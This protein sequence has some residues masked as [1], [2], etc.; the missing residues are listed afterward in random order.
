MAYRFD[1][2]ELDPDAAVLRRDGEPVEVQPKVLDLLVLAVENAGRLL[3]KEELMQ[4]LWPGVF[5]GEESLTQV[6]RKARLALGDD[7]Q[8]PRF[9]QT[10]PRRGYRFIAAAQTIESS[11][12]SPASALAA[13]APTLPIG[14][15]A[16]VPVSAGS[17]A[18]RGIALPLIAAGALAVLLSAAVVMLQRATRERAFEPSPFGRE[19]RLTDSPERESDPALA[20]AADRYAFVRP[21]ADGDLDLFVASLD[22]PASRLTATRAVESAPS[23]SPDGQT[24]LFTRADAGVSDLWE[25]PVRGGPGERVVAD[26]IFGV[27][28]PDGGRIAFLR[29]Q[30]DG[31][32]E[33]RALATGGGV[34]SSI[35][36][37]AEP[38]SALAWSPDGTRLAAVAG[39]HVLLGAAAP[40][41]RPQVLPARAEYVRSLVFDSTGEALVVDGS[42]GGPS[43]SGALWRLALDGGAPTPLV[44]GSG[45]IYN[46]SLARDGRRLLYVA[47]H[48]VRQIWRF[49]GEL[50]P[51][52]AL[53]LPIGIECFDVSPDGRQLSATDWVAPP[54]GGTLALVDLESGAEVGLGSGL[55]PAFSPDGR[56]LAYLGHG[57]DDRG[58]WVL[59]LASRARWRI[60]PD[61][62][63]VGLSE[64]NAARRPA[65]SADGGRLAYE[66]NGLPEGSGVAVVEIASGE[67]QLVAPEVFGNL[68]WSPDGRWI[69]A[70]GTGVESGFARIDVATGEVRRLAAGG[71]YRASAIWLDSGAVAVV[72]DQQRAPAQLIVDAATLE[73]RARRPFTVPLDASFWGIFEAQP[74]RR[75]GWLVVVE[76]YESDLYLA[77]RGGG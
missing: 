38:V 26:A 57:E 62:G 5:V 51:V 60:A 74:D 77:E 71:A 13:S 48:K 72:V 41:A 37:L 36:T 40:G 18:R 76:R 73:P 7:T 34:D 56:R 29:S 64:R 19:R 47:E 59:D 20:P 25:I 70:S 31:R 32:S 8:S 43:T 75:G 50:K 3:T 15:S 2:F 44:H 16:V 49:D 63:G 52:G 12:P 54:D 30:P 53:S 10:V 67:R 68:A 58:L 46:P 28:S 35:W 65:W 9:I 1:R 55:C 22:G 61:G 33:V 4:R 6:I 24:I 14:G 66:A 21:T 42:W 39:D 11:P 23:F 45:A 17:G 27:F 69:A